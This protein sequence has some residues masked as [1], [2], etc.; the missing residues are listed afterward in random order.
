[1]EVK[2]LLAKYEYD[3][4]KTVFIR[5]SALSYINGEKTEIGA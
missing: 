5:G 3:P 4:D 2:E 1:M